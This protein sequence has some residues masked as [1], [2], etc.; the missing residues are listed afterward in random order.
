MFFSPVLVESFTFLGFT[1]LLLTSALKLDAK[2]QIYC[3]IRESF[4]SHINFAAALFASERSQRSFAPLDFLGLAGL[5]VAIDLELPVETVGLDALLAILTIF[6][7]SS[8][9]SI[10]STL[11]LFLD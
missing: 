1:K 7:E 11:T 6:T 8:L 3:T 9:F 2:S 10:S 5:L 4:A